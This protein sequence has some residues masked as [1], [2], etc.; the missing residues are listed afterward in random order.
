MQVSLNSQKKKWKRTEEFGHAA[1][2]LHITAEVSDS[3]EE[4]ITVC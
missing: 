4:D 3:S 1:E 2:L